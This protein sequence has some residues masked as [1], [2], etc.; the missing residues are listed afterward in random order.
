MF[1]IKRPTTSLNHFFLHRRAISTQINYPKCIQ[2]LDVVADRVLSYGQELDA[3]HPG[4]KDKEY[5]ERRSHITQ[6]AKEY[7]HGNPL[8]R[9][10]YTLREKQTWKTVYNSLTALYPT[11]ACREYLEIFPR[12]QK[13]VGYSPDNIPQLADVSDFLKQETGFTLKPVM[14]LLSPRDFLNSLAFRVFNSTQY[15]RHHSVPLYTPEPD[16]IH[17]LIGHAPLFA[18]KEFADFSQQIG[19]LSLRCSESDLKKLSTAYWKT[20]EFG[21]FKYPD[22][23]FRAYGAGLLSSPGELLHSISHLARKEAFDAKV[24]ADKEYIITQYQ[25]PYYYTLSFEDM[26]K[27]VL[28]YAAKNFQQ[29]D[30]DLVWDEGT[31]SILEIPKGK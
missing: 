10:D 19:F 2:D 11:H 4:F 12:L 13:K 27:D 20:V 1:A 16:V 5:R 30:T 18:N 14:G 24:V 23:S 28:Q 3:D 31:E 15:V 17:E 26:K 8:P 29:Y 25:D 21:L 22:G 9:V 7:R 6:L